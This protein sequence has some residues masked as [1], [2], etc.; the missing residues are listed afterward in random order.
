MKFKGNKGFSFLLTVIVMLVVSV[1]V[2]SCIAIALANFNMKETKSNSVTT[3]YKAEEGM[4][5]IKAS[6][7]ER[8]FN[9]AKSAYT[10]IIKSSSTIP[11]SELNNEFKY[12]YY[13]M[14][15][16]EFTSVTSLTDNFKE[17][18]KDL[19]GFKCLG[20]EDLVFDDTTKSVKIE[21]IDISYTNSEDNFEE[22]I[23]TDIVIE[24][25]DTFKIFDKNSNITNIYSDYVLIG[26]RGI[27]FTGGAGVETN[28]KGNIYAG[29]SHGDNKYNI[30]EGII[31][32]GSNPNSTFNIICKN[33]I[34]RGSIT[35]YPTT[36]VNIKG[37]ES[38]IPNLYA[39]FLT[40]EKFGSNK[41]HNQNANL[42]FNCNSYI[43]QSTILNVPSSNVTLSGEYYG[44]SRATSDD[45]GSSFNINAGNI[46]ANLEGL[47]TLW[48]AGLSYL[49][50]PIGSGSSEYALGESLTSKHAQSMYLVPSK[51]IIDTVTGENLSNP[52][53][54]DIFN[55]KG[56]V[57]VDLSKN[58]Q[59]GGI[60][61]WCND[62]SHT[63]D[64]HYCENAIAYTP[65]Y[66]SYSHGN[67]LDNGRRV[68][69]Y[70]DIKSE[71]QGTFGNSYAGLYQD[72]MINR[73]ESFSLGNITINEDSLIK[74]V[75][76]VLSYNGESVDIERTYTRKNSSSL[77]NREYY[78]SEKYK[79][80]CSTLEEKKS[81][82]RNNS[83]FYHII[84]ASA[85]IGKPTK[86]STVSWL[87]SNDIIDFQVIE[88]TE[89]GEKLYFVVA[90]GGV[91]IQGNFKGVVIST[92]S[93]K[94]Q[95][96]VSIVGS[97]ISGDLI[98]FSG[99]S[100][101]NLYVQDSNSNPLN[102]LLEEYD[103][104]ENI[105]LYFNE[106]NDGLDISDSDLKQYVNYRNWVIK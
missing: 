72:Y 53:D 60:D 59:Y 92:G 41:A 105:R 19:E 14:L 29:V 9:C 12:V 97:L 28:I 45:N 52:I 16:K 66:V 30:D 34:T 25:P 36:S 21:G 87:K 17:C 94:V 78:I 5:L 79:S 13:E 102:F 11:S 84:D 31:F 47:N 18:I 46:N 95:G 43:E 90:D 103:E 6:I 7:E 91:T 3:Y 22:E 38:F 50:I 8:C 51:C 77:R 76:G 88:D 82:I 20:V 104:R 99:A 15:K 1:I 55:E 44:Y 69:L 86:T 2:A 106:L 42:N 61:L 26:D 71:K 57:I 101:C 68:Y 80:L 40:T 49:D 63:D 85:I 64:D 75:G 89:T 4:D 67:S 74:T 39:R 24:C 62:P 96:S 70:L 65:V 58:V 27:H 100:N 56:R 54:V 33:L 98:D 81:S 35:V 93:I 32:G 10:T 83:C 48:I 73:A 37:T 23:M